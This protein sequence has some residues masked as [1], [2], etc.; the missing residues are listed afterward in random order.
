MN[1]VT[2][3]PDGWPVIT[4]GTKKCSIVTLAAAN[5]AKKPVNPFSGNFTFRDDFEN[6][7]LN[8]RYTFLRTV[9][10]K[11]YSTACK[12]RVPEFAVTAANG[13][14][15]RKSFVCWLPAIAPPGFSFHPVKFCS[16]CRK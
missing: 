16:C 10:D 7:P 11:W 2:W 1:P 3:T 9:T 6:K 8:V 15:K 5:V 13:E 14:R 12:E 4:K